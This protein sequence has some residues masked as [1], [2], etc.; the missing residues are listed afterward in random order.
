[1]SL[2][3]RTAFFSFVLAC[4][5]TA[6]EI[7]P[8]TERAW[9]AGKIY[10]SAVQYFAH[11]QDVPDLDVDAAYRRYL[12]QVLTSG[13]R[14]AF[15][16]STMEFL[17]AFR[18]S[19]TTLIDQ[20]LIKTNGGLPFTAGYVGETWIVLESWTDGLKR[21]DVI[22]SIDGEPFEQLFVRMRRFI[23]ASTQGWARH[24]LF[25]R[26]GEMAAYAHLLPDRFVLGLNGSRN[27]SIDRGAMAASKLSGTEG[28][29][30]EAGK[31]AYI[32]IP[33]FFT[34]EYEKR[35]IEL[36]GQFRN[37]TALIVDVRGN[38][39]GNTPAQLTSELMDRPYRWWTESTPVTL[40]YFRFRAS[41][42][43]W[44]LQ[45]FARPELLWRNRPQQP[46]KEFFKGKL[47]LLVDA[48]CHSA[49]EDFVMP[50]KDNRRATL[51]GEPTAGSTGQPYMLEAGHGMLVMIGAKREMF[52]DGSQFRAL[53]SHRTSPW[54]H[55]LRI[56]AEAGTPFWKLHARL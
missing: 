21:G 48:G 55:R 30:L 45:P 44:E 50:F 16:R 18:N 26:M 36:L 11:W 32:R 46:A 19:H 7:L 37:A 29:W 10:S 9:M 49:C 40:P 2:V 52:P 24:A 6:Q 1:M 56:F 4:A 38:T 14:R 17:A 53:V 8:L 23:P 27:V 31:L 28:R 34:P 20:S 41:Q 13:D 39:G 3:F 54:R 43:S 33:S 25:A 22:E 5:A 47:A 51:V 15:A 35:A 42:G 12:D